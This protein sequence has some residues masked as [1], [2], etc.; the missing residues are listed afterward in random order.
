MEEFN[1]QVIKGDVVVVNFPFTD[2]SD[3]KIRPALVVGKS[4][5]NITICVITHNSG[6]EWEVTLNDEDFKNGKLDLKSFIQPTGLATISI[7]VI[8][9]KV[10][11]VKDS[12]LT[13]VITKII[14]Y[15]SQANTDTVSTSKALERPSYL[16]QKNRN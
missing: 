10:G 3:A 4:K 8:K 16:Q 15:L 9:K 7:S 1:G 2:G 13:E 5:K 12:K 6:R 11:S 14:E